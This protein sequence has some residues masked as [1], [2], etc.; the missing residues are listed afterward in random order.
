MADSRHVDQSVEV[1]IRVSTSKRGSKKDK[2]DGENS[3]MLQWQHQLSRLMIKIKDSECV[4]I[5]I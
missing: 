1:H 2:A 3:D 5:R 4:D